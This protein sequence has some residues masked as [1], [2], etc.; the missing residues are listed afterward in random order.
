MDL[1]IWKERYKENLAGAKPSGA[2]GRSNANAIH[3]A[4]DTRHVLCRRLSCTYALA[5]DGRVSL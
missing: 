1:K 4:F 3:G 5:M 2:G